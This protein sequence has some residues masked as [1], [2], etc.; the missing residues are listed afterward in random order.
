MLYSEA[1]LALGHLQAAVLRMQMSKGANTAAELRTLLSQ[2]GLAASKLRGFRDKHLDNLL[3]KGLST[4]DLLAT[5]DEAALTEPPPLPI[6]LRRAL[7]DK[8]NPGARPAGAGG[9]CS[10]CCI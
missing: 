5:A 6:T 9:S 8:F 2:A 7:L 4:L 10:I 3:D 1:V